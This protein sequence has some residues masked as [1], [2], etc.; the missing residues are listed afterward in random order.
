MI[1]YCPAGVDVEVDNVSVVV[2]PGVQG[3]TENED[4]APEGRPE[5]LNETGSMGPAVPVAVIVS[6]VD[7]P[8]VR[9]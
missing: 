5:I 9:I 2:H 4:V 1:G 3:E 7:W 6:D 8:C